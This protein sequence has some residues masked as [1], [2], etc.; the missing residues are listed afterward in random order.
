M[1]LECTLDIERVADELV[2]RM[3]ADQAG[4]FATLLSAS[5]AQ[6]REVAAA[7]RESAGD[8]EAVARHRAALERHDAGLI[9][10]T[11]GRDDHRTEGER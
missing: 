9:P 5:G 7:I 4:V 3:P 1:K 10:R 11:S 6:G 8:E 2:I